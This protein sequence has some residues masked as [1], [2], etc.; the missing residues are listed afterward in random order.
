MTSKTRYRQLPIPDPGLSGPE[1]IIYDIDQ[2]C[3]C[4]DGAQGCIYGQGTQARPNWGQCNSAAS[5]PAMRP[6]R[7][8]MIV[9]NPGPDRQAG[10]S[11]PASISAY[12]AG[13]TQYRRS[14][15][16]LYRVSSYLAFEAQMLRDPTSSR[17]SAAFCMSR[18]SMIFL[19]RSRAGSCVRFARGTRGP[20][21][22]QPIRQDHGGCYCPPAG[23]LR[24]WRETLGPLPVPLVLSRNQ[25]PPPP[26][27]ELPLG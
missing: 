1:P 21:R 24:C 5:C 13:A 11:V 4:G 25:L 22:P 19:R 9:R 18:P 8:Q 26:Y 15:P 17:A 27:M 7:I 14:G 20:A 2:D 3:A 10:L 12:F 16:C 23:G 6:S